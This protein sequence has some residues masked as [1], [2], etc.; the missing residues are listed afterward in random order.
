M[1][2]SSRKASEPS[3]SR[4]ELMHHSLHE[5]C[6]IKRNH[7]ELLQVLIDSQHPYWEPD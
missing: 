1:K 7:M 4:A 3:A 6:G 2:V 5:M